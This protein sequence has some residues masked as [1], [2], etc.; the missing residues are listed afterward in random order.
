MPEEEPGGAEDLR[1]RRPNFLEFA[2]EEA[3]EGA[4]VELEEEEVE[5]EPKG[6]RL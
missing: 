1:K 2:E 5:E 3:G 4:R 6:E